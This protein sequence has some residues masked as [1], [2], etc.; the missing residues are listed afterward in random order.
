MTTWICSQLGARENYAVARALHREQRLSSLYTDIWN[1][2]NR[3]SPDLANANVHH[4]TRRF[5]LRKV[6]QKTP[7]KISHDDDLYDRLVAQHLRNNKSDS[8]I[9]FAYSYAS[10]Q[11]LGTAKSLG[12]KTVLG[13][14]NPGP[15]EADIVV[16]EFR[17]FHDGKYPPTVPNSQYWKR[18]ERKLRC[19][20]LLW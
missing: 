5:L 6:L 11:S 13:Q 9:F 1:V 16:E 20:M 15:A 2:Q 7:I 19:L 10:L 14:I 12:Y 18:W 3:Y 8:K 17:K 4:F